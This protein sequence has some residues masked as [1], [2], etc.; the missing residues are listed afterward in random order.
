[1]FT[2]VVMGIIFFQLD[3]S[4]EGIQNR[5]V[6][7]PLFRHVCLYTCEWVFHNMVVYLKN[8]FD[9]NAKV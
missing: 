8:D 7:N 3:F 2:A 4:F 1:M 5:S 6:C 9:F